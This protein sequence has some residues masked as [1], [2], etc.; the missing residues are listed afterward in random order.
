MKRRKKGLAVFV[1][2]TIFF[3][4]APVHAAN[5]GPYNLILSWTGDTAHTMTASWR[6]AAQKQA[7][8]QVIS[9]TQYDKT[10][11]DGAKE[12][13][14]S[15][16]DISL[17]GTG[18]W[19]YEATATGLT[20]GTVYAYR[21]GGQGDWSAESEFTTAQAASDS[22]TFAYMGDIQTASDSEKEYALWG[23]LA[24][25][26]KRLYPELSFAVLGGDIVENGTS[27]KLF[28][29]FLQ[30]ASPVFSQIPLMATNGNHESNFP[31]TGKPELYR[32]EFALP[33]DGPA[34][35]SEEFYSFDVGNCH[36]LVLNSWIFS[37]EQKL[38]NDDDAR[39]NTWIKRD[40]ATSTADWQ[41][42][43]THVPV[44]ALHSDTTAAAVRRE[45]AP[46]FEQYGVDLVFEGHQHVYSRSYPLTE[47]KI[48]YENGVT[49]IMGN[50]GQKFYSSADETFS[51]KTIYNTA[52]YQITQIHGN[53]MTVQTLDVNGNELD[54]DSLSRRDLRLTRQAYIETLWKAAGSPAPKAPSPFR[55]AKT[56]SAAW[57][58]E[59]GIITG[60][61]GGRFGPNDSI[62]SRQV[63]WILG[64]MKT[65]T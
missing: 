28:D 57:A 22:V 35:F 3:L 13:P 34:G 9:K 36:V 41:V 48:D 50:A 29:E 65:G 6:G 39:I 43:V 4:I 49:Y 61:G 8:M 2:L 58:Y 52:T 17:D 12:F 33:T 30:N 44:Y 38:T 10:G 19:H 16:R 11:F 45:W 55:D 20:A 23:K 32:E 14:A 64:R 21:V 18:T 25:N 62:T 24:E 60:Y 47:G 53:A 42:V 5:G 15:C 59:S 26:M 27:T 54:C 51:E 1:I 63:G 37:G 7:V 56:P 31:D 40:L 46:I